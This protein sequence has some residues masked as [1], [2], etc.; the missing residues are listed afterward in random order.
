LKSGTRQCASLEPGGLRP[1]AKSVC[2]TF[3]YQFS[4]NTMQTSSTK[5]IAQAFAGRGSRIGLV[6]F[7]PAGYPDLAS[8]AAVIAAMDRAGAAAIEVGF[9]FSDPIADGPTIQE[10]FTLALAKKVKVTEI[11]QTVQGI[12][13]QLAAPLVAMLSYSIVFRYGAERFFADVK[14]AGFSGL[15]IPDLPPPQAQKTCDLIQA[16]GLDTI[17]LI[18][19]T[20]TAARRAEICK[21]CSGFVYYLSVSGITGIRDELP[22]GIPENVRQIK[23]MTDKPV[24]VGF[25]ISKPRHVASLNGVADGAIV[26]SAIVKKM[27]NATDQTPQSLAKMVGE[28]C[29]QLLGPV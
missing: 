25:G 27:L 22:P 16:A 20:T 2:D 23:G 6:P 13:P 17:F 4:M 28:Y 19:P 3:G 11:L 5:S 12:A 7:V 8:T 24:C 9:P 14:R 21:L 1:P 26:G 18:A 10:A 29:T 15:I